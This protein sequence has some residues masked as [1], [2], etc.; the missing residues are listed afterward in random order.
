MNIYRV[1]QTKNI[2]WDTYDSFVIAAET[3]EEA[4]NTYPTGIKI[5]VNDYIDFG[6]WCEPMYVKVEM[7]GTAVDGVCGVIC[8]SFNAG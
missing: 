4:R 7:I 8:A 6:A 5:K 2:D 3:E 1:S